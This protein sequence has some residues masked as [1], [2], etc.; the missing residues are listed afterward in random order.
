MKRRLSPDEAQVWSRVASTVTPLDHPRTGEGDNRDA[1]VEGLAQA[2]T[3]GPDHARVPLHH[4]SHGS[5]PHAGEVLKPRPL[6]AHGLDAGWDKKLA[7]GLAAPDYTLDLHGHSLDAAYLR[8]D[9]GLA[10][11]LALGARMVLV[12]TGRPRP[13]EA[14]DR[15]NRRGAIR[16]KLLDWLAAGPYG[17]SIAAVRPAHRRHG[18]PGAVYVILRRRK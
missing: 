1:M 5:P 10:Q 13:A 15:G 12:I 8:L 6:D 14:A 16:A 11:A 18:G 9:R 4:T 2:I 17:A 3:T 7:R